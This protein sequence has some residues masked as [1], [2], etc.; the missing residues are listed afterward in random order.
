M[1]PRGG[2][3]RE[4][5]YCRLR[6]HFQFQNQLMLFP[7]I[8]HRIRFSVNIY[9]SETAIPRFLHIA[10][11]FSP[12]TVDA[13]FSH[14]GTG[15]VPALKNCDGMWDTEGH[16]QR[17]IKIT[18]S[19]LAV[20]SQLLDS[21]DSK[22]IEARLPALHSNDLL[23]V[24]KKI[25]QQKRKIRELHQQ[26]YFTK[27]FD[28]TGAQH[29]GL[30]RRATRFP[31]GLH[32]FIYSGPH[33]SIGNPLYKTPRDRCKSKADYDV[34]DL[35]SVSADYIPRANYRPEWNLAGK[36]QDS[37]VNRIPVV[38][39]CAGDSPRSKRIVT[40]MYRCIFREMTGPSSERSLI[41]A[42]IPPASS[43][44]NTCISAS[45]ADS[46]QLLDFHGACIS[47]PLDFFVKTLGASHIHRA[48]LESFPSPD[49]G[50]Q[51][52][53]LIH[54]RV[55]VLNCLTQYYSQLWCDS[56]QPQ[57]RQDS[58]TKD[59][60]R[61]RRDLFG[62]LNQDWNQEY[63][64]R[65]YFERRQALVEVDVLVSM[66]L[67]L[68]LEELISIYRVQFPVL[69][70]NER[71]TWF[72]ASGRIVFTA[73][74]GLSGV[75]VPRRAILGDTSYGL[76]TSDSHKENIALGWEDICDLSQGIVTRD[77][78]DDSQFGG[79]TRKTIQY[80]AP[81]DLC[82]RESDYRVAW[83]GFERRIKGSEAR[84]S[85]PM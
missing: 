13:C 84:S 77:V 68:N 67:G 81:F 24:L 29:D 57:Y 40:N 45:F 14:D 33:I 43:H 50:A 47:L 46:S 19:E 12:T 39:W 20:F 2:G 55:L 64:I 83:D 60:V 44:I 52:R 6:A 3:L 16:A 58:W 82:D 1:T 79:P 11:I 35:T 54:L 28:E 75:G 71:D 30:I 17:I 85:D 31:E 53:L 66:V 37:L 78:L 5:I 69:Q 4:E 76:I 72:D 21:D 22:P 70:Q 42:L 15:S 74:K 65:S 51:I 48:L 18:M 41:S 61:L 80:H 9:S 59:D 63:A 32:D 7:E 36:G 23:A 25:S 49:L 73:S 62:S 38:P 34:I 8:G 10:N 26:F 56:W 27:M